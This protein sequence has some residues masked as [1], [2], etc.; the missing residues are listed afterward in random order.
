ML[1]LQRA[2]HPQLKKAQPC[3]QDRSY[4]HAIPCLS[5]SQGLSPSVF[6]EC[7]PQHSVSSPSVLLVVELAPVLWQLKVYLSDECVEMTCWDC[8]LPAQL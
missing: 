2:P 3:P 5:F 7:L 8:P 6:V 1:A 4:A